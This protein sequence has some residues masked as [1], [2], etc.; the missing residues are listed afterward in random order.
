M[1]VHLAALGVCPLPSGEL[2]IVFTS[3]FDR[4]ALGVDYSLLFTFFSFFSLAGNLKVFFASEIA[5]S[6]HILLF[7]ALACQIM[8][9]VPARL[10]LVAEFTQNWKALLWSAN[11]GGFG[12]LFCS[13][14]NLVTYKAYVA[15]CTHG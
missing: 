7:T 14:A 2:V 10:H 5:H 1:V 9:N 8:S 4:R 3:L 11:A 15:R 12:V 6:G 13:L